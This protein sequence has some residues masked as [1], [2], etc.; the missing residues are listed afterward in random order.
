MNRGAELHFDSVLDALVQVTDDPT[1]SARLSELARTRDQ[2]L[3][4]AVMREPYLSLLLEGTK[5]IE[6]RFSARRIQ[7]FGR[8]HPGD[9]LALKRQSGPLVG[10]ALVTEARFYELD[11]E[12]L[13]SLRDQYAPELAAT[14]DRFWQERSQA[15]Y[16]TLIDVVDPS[17]VPE[18]A[19]R[20][21]DR[22]GWASLAPLTPALLG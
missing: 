22:R 13:Q 4:V 11:A 2:V 5:T 3:H 10:L 20:K 21:R 9:V 1:W 16:A 19:V 14:D 6:S 18:V 15:A 8:V 17:V 12:V 7:P